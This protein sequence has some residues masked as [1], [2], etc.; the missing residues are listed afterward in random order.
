LQQK[1]DF[2]VFQ[3]KKKEKHD[4]QTDLPH[5]T[6][7][8]PLESNILGQIVIPSEREGVCH[9]RYADEEAVDEVTAAVEARAD[10]VP[11]G[12]LSS[13]QGQLD[14]MVVQIL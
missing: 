11:G 9:T 4:K 7:A 2:I 14:L 1:H 12:H 5:Q 6:T 10:L 8:I 3:S 13:L